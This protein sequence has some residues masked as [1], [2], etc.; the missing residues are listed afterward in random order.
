MT[1][2]WH[3]SLFVLLTFQGQ[4]DW[5]RR[6]HILFRPLSLLFNWNIVMEALDDDNV[7]YVHIWVKIRIRRGK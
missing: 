1:R 3:S 5:R 7:T 2:A 6:L 4:H